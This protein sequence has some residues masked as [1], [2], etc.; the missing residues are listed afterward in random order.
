[1]VNDKTKKKKY[2]EMTLYWDQRFV[3][4]TGNMKALLAH[5]HSIVCDNDIGGLFLGYPKSCQ[6]AAH[7]SKIHFNFHFMI[8]HM[9]VSKM[10]RKVFSL[11]RKYVL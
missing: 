9:K 2:N 10:L 11:K 8:L 5:I 6:M 7:N 3:S 1:M 4:S